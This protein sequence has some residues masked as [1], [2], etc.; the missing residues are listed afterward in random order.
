M[1]Y[2]ILSYNGEVKTAPSQFLS[3]IL[4]LSVITLAV[5][6]SA[7]FTE[8]LL[9]KTFFY[10]LYMNEKLMKWL[11]RTVIRLIYCSI[12][13]FTSNYNSKSFYYSLVNTVT[14]KVFHN[15]RLSATSLTP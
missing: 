8:K 11:L 6:F 10:V 7:L 5:Y 9:A 4:R 13:L 15:Q 1:F 3:V 2:S 14:L 12:Y